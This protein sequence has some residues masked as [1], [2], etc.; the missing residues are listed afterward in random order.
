MINK[1]KLHQQAERILA[2]FN[3]HKVI[4]FLEDYCS[5]IGDDLRAKSLC[6]IPALKESLESALE[7]FIDSYTNTEGAFI[8]TYHSDGWQIECIHEYGEDEPGLSVKYILLVEE[9]DYRMAEE[10][11]GIKK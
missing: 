3:W 6:S 1:D 5:Y 2:T 8:Q 9:F 10:Y 7:S 4:H 11:L